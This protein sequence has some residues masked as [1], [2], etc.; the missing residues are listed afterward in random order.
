VI[1]AAKNLLLAEMFPTRR[2]GP[3]GS[4]APTFKK[5]ALSALAV[6]QLGTF[7][8]SVLRNSEKKAK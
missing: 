1:I 2:T 7:V 6:K 3:G 8:Q 4:F 5:S